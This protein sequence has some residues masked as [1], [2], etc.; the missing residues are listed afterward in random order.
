M[1]PNT[2]S[3]FNIALGQ[4]SIF[5]QIGNKLSNFLIKVLA[6]GWKSSY[7]MMLYQHKKSLLLYLL[8]GRMAAEQ[9]WI[10]Q[11]NCASCKSC[12]GES[13]VKEVEKNL[14]NF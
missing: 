8:S 13:R 6:L 5:Q 7:N 3:L 11:R 14:E 2:L 9:V 4:T 1:K 10:L 12:R